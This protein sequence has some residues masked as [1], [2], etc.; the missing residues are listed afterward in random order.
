MGNLLRQEER[1]AELERAEQNYVTPETMTQPQESRTEFREFIPENGRVRNEESSDTGRSEIIHL[2]NEGDLI[3]DEAVAR[4]GN[5]TST[6]RTNLNSTAAGTFAGISDEVGAIREAAVHGTALF[7]GPGGILDVDATRAAARGDD[8]IGRV[9]LNETAAGTFAGIDDE[10]KAIREAAENTT[11]LIISPDGIFEIDE[12]IAML[13][14][15]DS[16]RRVNLE[17]MAPDGMF[18]GISDEV[19]A[20]REAAEHGSPLYMGSDGV[21]DVSATR[22]A[23]R[24]DDSIVRVNL[25]ETAANG[26]AAEMQ[27]YKRDPVLF[28]AEVAGMKQCY[29]GAQLCYLKNGQAFWN[30]TLKIK[31]GEKIKPYTLILVYDTD[32]PNNQSFGGSVKAIPIKPNLEEIQERA[33]SLGKSYVPHI[34]PA[35]LSKGL[36]MQYLCTARITDV[37]DGKSRAASAV[38]AASWAAKWLYFYEAGLVDDV[39]WKEFCKD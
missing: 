13:R 28:N 22:A 12:T 25:N 18:A 27:W 8:S 11:P 7:M 37:P 6:E 35:S 17:I 36:D 34:V 4:N 14:G 21:L 15:D 38:T 3:P 20:I 9:N 2:N 33:R 5:D 10:I 19:G 32:H 26:F 30:L 31:V 16:I 24:G 23:A 29:P 39:I 1:R